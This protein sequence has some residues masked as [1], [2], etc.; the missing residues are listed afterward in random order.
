MAERVLDRNAVNRVAA[1]TFRWTTH[2][3]LCDVRCIRGYHGHVVVLKETHDNDAL[4]PWL[5]LV[6]LAHAKGDPALYRPLMAPRWVY[7]CAMVRS[8][9]F[10]LF[11]SLVARNQALWEALRRGI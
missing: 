1:W 8:V 10:G 2:A 5:D 6:L 9:Q 4:R 3:H 7:M 11:A